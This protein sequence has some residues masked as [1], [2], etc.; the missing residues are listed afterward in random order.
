MRFL[1]AVLFFIIMAGNVAMAEEEKKDSKKRFITKYYYI[2]AYI[3]NKGW[4][5]SLP[6]SLYSYK[7]GDTILQKPVFRHDETVYIVT[8][9]SKG[10]I[11]RVL[12]VSFWLQRSSKY[13]KP[14]EIYTVDHFTRDGKVKLR[15][16][17]HT[18]IDW[19]N[20]KKIEYFK[21]QQ[22]V[23]VEK[24]EKGKVTETKKYTPNPQ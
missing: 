3:E 18:A 8:Y 23:K 22:L 9:D 10:D 24:Y 15:V 12:R 17:Y 21:N 4:F 16:T 11:V 5:F 13:L 6:K 19:D 1:L 2:G 20:A 7:K 14:L